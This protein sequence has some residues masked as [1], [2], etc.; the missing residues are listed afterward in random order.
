MSKAPIP[1]DVR[2]ARLRTIARQNGGAVPVPFLGLT[3]QTRGGAY[4][5][6]R[7]GATVVF[8]LALALV[9][10]MATGFTIGIAGNGRDVIRVVLAVLYDLTAIAG[11]RS[12]LR[13]LAAAPLDDRGRIVGSA[14]P[15]GL[16]A[17]VLAPYGTGLVL[18]MLLA[19]FR[20]DFI[21]ENSAR[22]FSGT[23]A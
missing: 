7:A 5:R 19:T 15:N 14:V 17:L 16:L 18:T 2:R 23:I 22:E 20:R 11:I 21:G 6:R 3:W 4:W 13:T 1:D 12:G 8:L 10:G 9:G